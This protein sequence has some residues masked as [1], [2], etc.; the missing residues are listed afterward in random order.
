MTAIKRFTI[1]MNDQNRCPVAA[2]TSRKTI[3]YTDRLVFF[4]WV[5]ENNGKFFCK[6]LKL[7]FSISSS[8]FEASQ[9]V[10]KF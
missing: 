4:V 10:E 5:V 6:R 1:K 9:E 8:G 3:A 2:I 7:D